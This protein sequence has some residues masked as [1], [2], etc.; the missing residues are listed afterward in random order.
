VKLSQSFEQVGKEA[1]RVE[2]SHIGSPAV[3]GDHREHGKLFSIHL[4]PLDAKRIVLPSWR[5]TRWSLRRLF[6]KVIV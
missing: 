3:F 5:P 4:H 6:K 1:E 2:R